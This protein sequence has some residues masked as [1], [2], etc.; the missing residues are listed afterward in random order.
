MK[1]RIDGAWRDITGGRVRINDTWRR[2]VSAQ[3]F[4]GGAWRE[5]AS[6]IQPMTFAVT[7]ETITRSGQVGTTRAT[8]AVTGTPTG[9]RTPY[10]YAWTRL[11]GDPAIT[12]TN[13]SAAVTTF[14]RFLGSEGTFSAVFQC[15]CTDTNGTTLTDTVTVTFVASD[16]VIEE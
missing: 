6:F 14:Q 12:I 4:I 7:P 16:F 15:A 3:A 11:S 2:L 8:A 1:A 9:G 10:T 13:P 5:V